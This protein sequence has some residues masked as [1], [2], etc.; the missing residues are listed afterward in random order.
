MVITL[1]HREHVD[2]VTSR[3]GPSVTCAPRRRKVKELGSG[4]AALSTRQWNGIEEHLKLAYKVQRPH[5]AVH[6]STKERPLAAA[7][8]SARRRSGVLSTASM[9]ISVLAI[10]LA[11]VIAVDDV[12]NP[13]IPAFPVVI[14]YL[15][16]A[17]GVVLVAAIAGRD[18]AAAEAARVIL[19]RRT[20]L[21]DDGNAGPSHVTGREESQSVAGRTVVHLTLFGFGSA[22]HP[23]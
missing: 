8:Y 23:R 21:A 4:P 12:A 18:A 7:A 20:R 13:P 19:E 3:C 2:K 15:V 9:T 5:P 1:S 22:R 17:A 14:V 11:L 6:L 10:A 16:M